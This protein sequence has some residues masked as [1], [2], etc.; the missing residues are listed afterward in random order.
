MQTPEGHEQNKNQL[1]ER[2]ET[3]TKAKKPIVRNQA[4]IERMTAQMTGVDKKLVKTVFDSF[5]EN[6]CN[7]LEYG[8]TVKLHGKGQFYLSHR[9]RRIGRNPA[10]GEEHIVP[11]R[12][13]MAF[14]TSPAYAKKLRKRRIELRSYPP[15]PDGVDDTRIREAK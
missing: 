4:Y 14:Q 13:A 7:E 15:S 12:E 8:N 1:S 6:I 5:W 2:S 9:S 11:E 3:E 10:T